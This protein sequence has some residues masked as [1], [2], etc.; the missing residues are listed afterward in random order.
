MVTQTA[1]TRERLYPD[2]PDRELLDDERRAVWA[3]LPARSELTMCTV[4]RRTVFER[5]AE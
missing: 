2:V 1:A 4:S 5:K 3:A